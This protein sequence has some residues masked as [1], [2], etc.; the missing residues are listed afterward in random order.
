MVAVLGLALGAPQSDAAVQGPVTPTDWL[1]VDWNEHDGLNSRIH[2]GVT[3]LLVYVEDDNADIG[4]YQVIFADA[5][6]ILWDAT[7]GLL[8]IERVVFTFCDSA[9]RTA[10][11]LIVSDLGCPDSPPAS[12]VTLKKVLIDDCFITYGAE[13]VGA[14]GGEPLEPATMVAHELGHYYWGLGDEYQGTRLMLPLAWRGLVMGYV[15]DRRRGR[16]IGDSALF[17]A[18]GP[19]PHACLMTASTYAPYPGHRSAFCTPE[20]LGDASTRHSGGG[21]VNTWPS[22]WPFAYLMND[23]ERDHGE[24]CWETIWDHPVNALPRSDRAPVAGNRTFRPPDFSPPQNC[25]PC[26]VSARTTVVAPPVAIGDL[27]G[28]GTD[29]LALLGPLFPTAQVPPPSSSTVAIESDTYRSWLA[30]TSA[31]YVMQ[32][33]VF[34]WGSATCEPLWRVDLSD[35]SMLLGAGGLRE[36]ELA[37][38]PE[39]MRGLHV[40]PDLDLDGVVELGVPLRAASGPLEQVLVLSGRTGQNLGSIDTQHRAL[41]TSSSVPDLAVVALEGAGCTALWFLPPWVHPLPD[42]TLADGAMPQAVL[43]LGN[44][45]ADRDGDGV[46][47]LLG[48]TGDARSRRYLSGRTGKALETQFFA[49]DLNQRQQG[50]GAPDNRPHPEL[51]RAQLPVHPTGLVERL[52]R[53]SLPNEIDSFF[54]W[55]YDWLAH[56]ALLKAQVPGQQSPVIARISVI[57][58]LPSTGSSASAPHAEDGFEVTSSWGDDEEPMSGNETRAWRSMKCKLDWWL[59]VPFTDGWRW[60]SDFDGDGG[61]DLLI[62]KFR[63]E[64]GAS[65]AFR[66]GQMVLEY[67]L[68]SNGAFRAGAMPVHDPI[69]MVSRQATNPSDESPLFSLGRRGLTGTALGYR[70]R[71][72]GDPLFGWSRIQTLR[73]E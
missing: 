45:S 61:L 60:V 37:K 17:C 43:P 10:D 50:Y 39:C 55:D 8:R 14:A 26:D 67:V 31:Q 20:D 22:L 35:W 2:D 32:P 11:V 68:I 65:G 42:G 1:S 63:A 9:W 19:D 13:R 30:A 58:V 62:Y 49:S 41:A 21:W 6:N 24:S 36:L 59:N 23:Q 54:A 7:G 73:F 51:F 25:D 71:L 44:V 33:S 15:E 69:G 56:S 66:N 70:S 47:E 72:V 3:D 46:P 16:V 53:R 40:L 28:D 48:V 38:S 5:A 64:M 52:R 27:D 29:E 34:V 18:V 12:A 4:A 57:E